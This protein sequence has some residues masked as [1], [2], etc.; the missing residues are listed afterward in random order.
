MKLWWLA[1]ISTGAFSLYN[2]PGRVRLFSNMQEGGLRWF[3]NKLERERE[4]EPDWPY[5]TRFEI[6]V[7]FWKKVKVIKFGRAAQYY[8]NN[9]L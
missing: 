3:S 4:R 1:L 2:E 9:D 6:F 8:S 5:D 7:D